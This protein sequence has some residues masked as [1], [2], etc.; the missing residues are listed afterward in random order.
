MAE[1]A[2]RGIPFLAVPA[3]ATIFP[4]RSKLVPAGL[5]ASGNRSSGRRPAANLDGTL[6]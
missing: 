2:A 6:C 1:A 4:A 5:R 3:A